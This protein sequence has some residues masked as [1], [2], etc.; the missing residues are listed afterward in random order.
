M[1]SRSAYGWSRSARRS[2]LR[3]TTSSTARS[4]RSSASDATWAAY[5]SRCSETSTCAPTQWVTAPSGPVRGASESCVHTA[6]PSRR[7]VRTV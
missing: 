7:N 1:M 3:A 2:E 6:T 5:R 4:R